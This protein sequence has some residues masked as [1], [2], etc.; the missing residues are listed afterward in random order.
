MLPL[1]QVAAMPLCPARIA[2]LSPDSA[3]AGRSPL[4]RHY[5]L[6]KFTCYLLSLLQRV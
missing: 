1:R 5:A 2:L 3:D 6:Y 4:F